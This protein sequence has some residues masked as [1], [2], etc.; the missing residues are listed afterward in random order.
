M[1]YNYLRDSFNSTHTRKSNFFSSTATHEME[2]L[3]FFADMEDISKAFWVA[4]RGR[5]RSHPHT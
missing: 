5:P 1:M 4:R 2:D 3:W